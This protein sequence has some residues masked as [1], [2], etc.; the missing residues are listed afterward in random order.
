MR[1]VSRGL[2]ALVALV[3][4]S[5]SAPAAAQ[6][7]SQ[8]LSAIPLREVGPAAVGGRI[9]DIAVNPLDKSTWYVA[10]GSGGLW[11]TT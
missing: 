3:S 2:L 5:A 1:F 4:F 11:K 7:V 9:A 8:A 6:S 10:V